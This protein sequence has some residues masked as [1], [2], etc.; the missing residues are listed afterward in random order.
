MG[1]DE[2]QCVLTFGG[3]ASSNIGVTVESYPGS[4]KPQKNVDTDIIPG[5][6]GDLIKDYKTY[7]NYEVTYTCHWRKNR[8]LYENA[9]YNTANN[10]SADYSVLPWLMLDGYQQL[11]DSFHPLHYRMAYI[12]N[13]FE[14]DNLMNQLGRAKIRFNAK[15]QWFRKSGETAITVSSSG[16]HMQNTGM[17]SLPLITVNGSGSCTVTIGAQSVS[18]SSIPESG[19]VLDSELQ[20]AY[21]PNKT[22]NFN[23]IVT[24]SGDKFP[25][26]VHGDN[27]ISYT[28][29]ITSIT[30]IPRWWD[31][32]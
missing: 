14:V 31:L 25:V 19:I 22:T 13:S 8:E 1:V 10:T 4:V 28:G 3:Y 7:K 15:P 27:I 16:Y 29:N 23:N 2:R 30:I 20:D 11:E 32:L 5:R 17:E 24:L 12:S 26:L 18:I 21:S 6:N 9:D